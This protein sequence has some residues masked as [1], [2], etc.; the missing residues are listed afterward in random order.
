M[1]ENASPKKEKIKIE[2]LT[3]SQ[4]TAQMLDDWLAQI[5]RSIPGLKINRQGLVDWLVSHRPAQLSARELSA[6]RGQLFDEIA[7]AEWAVK[8]LKKARELGESV[9]LADIMNGRVSNGG[10]SPEPTRKKRKAIVRNEQLADGGT[11]DGE[12][13]PNGE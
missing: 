9:A 7:F 11:G 4:G 10:S 2:R 5:R 3:I 6:I 1:T 8:E 13:H 12:I